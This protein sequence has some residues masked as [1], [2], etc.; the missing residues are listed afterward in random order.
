MSAYEVVR[1]D[2]IE[3]IDDGREPYRPVRHHLGITAFGVTSWTGKNAGD[4]IINEHA[5][6]QP[7]DSEELYVVLS[8][9]ARFE[10]GDDTVDAP[11]GT[12]VFVPVGPHRRT[13]YA[14]ADGTT[15]LA[16]GAPP[17][18][19][20]EATG[21]ELWMPLGR[22]YAAGDYEAA[23]EQGRELAEANPQY[24][25][26]L[27]N[28]ACCEALAGRSE[29]AIRHLRMAIERWDGAREL[30]RSDSDFDPIREEPGFEELVR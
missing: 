8:G 17:G 9:H 16:I 19:A 5:E 6:D 3:E 1:L 12:L 25:L 24:A 27:Y 14:E 18:Q 15:L 22:L 10:I 13:A 2:E 11:E 23:I 28:L 30:A 4:R 26:L 20:Y 29:D 21:W 7:G